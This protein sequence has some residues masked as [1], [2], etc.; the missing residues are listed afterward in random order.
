MPVTNDAVDMR[1]MIEGLS[2]GMK[3]GGNA[4]RGTKMFWVGGNRRECLGCG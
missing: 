2:P 3:N 4:D 1:V